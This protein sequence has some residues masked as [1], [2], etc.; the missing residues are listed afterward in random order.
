MNF[1]PPYEVCLSVHKLC[2]SIE[3]LISVLI[4]GMTHELR[5]IKLHPNAMTLST[6]VAL[7]KFTTENAF[8]MWNQ[9]HVFKI[10]YFIMS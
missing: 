4:K 6:I 9:M 5:H 1:S 7:L 10:T 8:G 3:F 2:L